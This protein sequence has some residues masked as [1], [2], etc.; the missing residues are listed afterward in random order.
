[1]SSLKLKQPI[2]IIYSRHSQIRKIGFT[3]SVNTG[4]LV[5]SAAARSNLK[6]VCL[7]LGGKSPAIIFNDADLDR[8]VAETTFSITFNSGQVCAANSRVYVQEDVSH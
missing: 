2:E 7:E 3:G 4:R 6:S 1:L 5:A 8:A